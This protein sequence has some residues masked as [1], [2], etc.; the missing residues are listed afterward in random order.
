M[1]SAMAGVGLVIAAAGTATAQDVTTDFDKSIDFSHYKTFAAQI[2]TSWA[3]PFAEKRALEEIVNTLTA[4]GWQ[5]ADEASADAV[6]MINGASQT[7]RDVNTFYSG[8]GYRWYGG[9]GMATTT[10]NEFKVGSMIVD[11]FDAKT[12]NLLWRGI[13]TDELSDSADKNQKKIVNAT[14]KMFKNFPP[15]PSK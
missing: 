5:Q 3:S 6:V 10:V 4:K 14:K 11:I 15:K 13:G 12:K 9:A 7:K 2:K 8:G 1:V